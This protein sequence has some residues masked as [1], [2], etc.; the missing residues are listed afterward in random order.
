MTMGHYA[1]ALLP[2]AKNKGWPLWLLLVCGQFGDLLWLALA[3]VGVEPTEPSSF[4]DVSIV[5]MKVS[6]LW[7][8]GLVAVL[9]QAALMGALVFAVWK[10]KALA[11]W[12][13]ALVVGH[14]V[15][16]FLC[17]WKHEAAG[18][19]S[20][21]LGLGLYEA[22]VTIFVALALEVAFGAACVWW[23]VRQREA[24]GDK[25][26]GR[27]KGVLYAVFAGGALLFAGNAT[28]SMRDLLARFN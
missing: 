23:F 19:G 10:D 18:A 6:M 9:V 13:A 27:A 15:C 12:A 8:H 7:S 22:P 5:N 4:L 2:W 11:G 24:V 28:T 3:V 1:T 17:G 14:L 26:S 25:L 16:D 20:L 21:K